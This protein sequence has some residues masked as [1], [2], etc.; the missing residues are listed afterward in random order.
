M[1]ERKKEILELAQ[2]LF[3]E[4]GYA[5]ASVRDIASSAGVEP[6][7]LYSHIKGKEEILDA[8]C[9]DMA[10]KF[11]TSIHEVND[12]YFDALQRLQMAVKSHIELLTKFPDASVVFLRDWRYLSDDRRAEFIALRDAYEAELRKIIQCGIDEGSF[13]ETDVKFATLTIL[14]SM[15]WVVEWYKEDGKLTTLQ[16]ADRITEFILQGLL[17]EVPPT[18]SN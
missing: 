18:Y 1:T 9:F 8:I 13:K 2:V 12:I 16:I 11:A 5:A 3:R 7:S 10:E 4:K 17:K 14:S 6:A 15:N